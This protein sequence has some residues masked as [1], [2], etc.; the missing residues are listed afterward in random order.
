MSDAF[1]P[2]LIAACG[3]TCGVCYAR[4]RRK[5]VCP[6]CRA[7]T[8]NLSISMARCRMKSCPQRRGDFCFACESFP[9]ADLKQLDKRYRTRYNVSPIANLE[10]IRD[11]GM[12]AFVQQE[13]G[14]WQVDGGLCCMHDGVIYPAE[15]LPK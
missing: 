5:S 3:L 1:A 8:E 4:L 15:Q 11:H 13:L 2:E 7:L 12:E 14:R 6:G 10:F 9:C